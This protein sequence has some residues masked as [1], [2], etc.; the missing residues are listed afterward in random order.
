MA[1]RVPTLKDKKFREWLEDKKNINSGLLL[2]LG[3]PG[4]IGSYKK[5]YLESK[6]KKKGTWSVSSRKRVKRRIATAKHV[7]RKSYTSKRK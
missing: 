5:E 3:T 7:K 2:T 4:T 1:K 6:K